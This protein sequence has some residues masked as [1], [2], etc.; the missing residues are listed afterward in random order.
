MISKI[1]LSSFFILGVL[2]LSYVRRLNLHKDIALSA[3]RVVCQLTFLGYILTWIFKT[4]HGAITL[5]AII[6]MTI[7]AAFNAKSRIN[8]KYQGLLLDN[9]MSITLAIWPIAYL[10]SFLIYETIWWKAELLL[11]LIGMLLGNALS[12]IATGVDQFT[13]LLHLQKNDLE[14]FIAMG[15]STPEATLPFKRKALKASMNPTINSMLS[16]GIVSIPGLMSGQILAGQSA[17][18]AASIQ[19]IMMFMICCSTFLGVYLGLNLCEKKLFNSYG[20]PCF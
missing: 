13:Q 9:L 7:M 1:L 15:A 3:L 14:N 6:F 12:G 11:P 2:I 4:S 17:G 8:Y 16:M 5:V 20:Q 18:L 10:G 19:I